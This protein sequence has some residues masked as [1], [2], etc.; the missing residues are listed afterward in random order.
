MLTCTPVNVQSEKCV[1][2]MNRQSEKVSAN[3]IQPTATK[4]NIR[5]MTLCHIKNVDIIGSPLWL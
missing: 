1:K 4:C 3:S 2:I 5:F